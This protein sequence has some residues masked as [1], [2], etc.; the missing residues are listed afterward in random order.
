MYQ[1]LSDK[2]KAIDANFKKELDFIAKATYLSDEG[3]REKAGEASQRRRQA[4]AE[5]QDIAR[6]RIEGERRKVA[7]DLAKLRE[8]DVERRRAILGDVVLSSIY[9]ERIAKMSSGDILKA[10]QEAAGDWE[11][12]IIVE[13]GSMIVEGRLDQ[14]NPT[15]DDFLAANEMTVAPVELRELEAKARDLRRGEEFVEGLD[16]IEWRQSMA[17]R[18]GLQVESMAEVEPTF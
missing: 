17:D 9:R 10:Y 6:T 7:G 4:I 13:Y 15:A 8:A 14:S 2:A 1:D 18:L 5:I 16:L 11:K 3:K 12:A